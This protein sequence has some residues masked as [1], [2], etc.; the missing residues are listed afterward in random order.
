MSL[1]FLNLAL[2]RAGMSFLARSCGQRRI[3]RAKIFSQPP[4]LDEETVGDVGKDGAIR[5]EVLFHAPQNAGGICRYCAEHEERF[6]ISSPA[7]K[8]GMLPRKA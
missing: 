8:R 7:P 2:A 1:S 4:A 3:V 6:R 5:D